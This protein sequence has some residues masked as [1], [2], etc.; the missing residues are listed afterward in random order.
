MATKSKKKTDFQRE[1][2]VLEKS[3][4]K[5]AGKYAKPKPKKQKNC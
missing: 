5:A 1:D 4:R 2:A 3:Y